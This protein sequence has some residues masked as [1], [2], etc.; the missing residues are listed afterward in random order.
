MREMENV[1]AFDAAHELLPIRLGDA[2]LGLLLGARLEDYG[3]A[4]LSQR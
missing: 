3:L 1:H 4:M 2:N